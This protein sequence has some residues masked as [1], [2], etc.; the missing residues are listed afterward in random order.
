MAGKG[1][2]FV[3]REAR[4]R[5]MELL[6]GFQMQ[7]KLPAGW[8]YCCLNTDNTKV[9][10][11]DGSI[12]SAHVTGKPQRCG[13]CKRLPDGTYLMRGAEYPFFQCDGAKQVPWFIIGAFD[14]GSAGWP[15][16]PGGAVPATDF[17]EFNLVNGSTLAQYRIPRESLSTLYQTPTFTYNDDPGFLQNFS[18][19]WKCAISPD[20]KY[21]TIVRVIYH[22]YEEVLITTATARN[23]LTQTFPEVFYAVIE[24]F[25]LGANVID[26]SQATVTQG[27][28]LYPYSG[29]QV[30]RYTPGF[31]N[32][33]TTVETQQVG[34]VIGYATDGSPII[35]LVGYAD[36]LADQVT[37]VDLEY[38]SA[39]WTALDIAGANSIQQGNDLIITAVE[40]VVFANDGVLETIHEYKNNSVSKTA[41]TSF[42]MFGVRSGN[43]TATWCVERPHQFNHSPVFGNTDYTNPYYDPAF[44][45]IGASHYVVDTMRYYGD[46]N[47][48]TGWTTS[49][50]KLKVVSPEHFTELRPNSL[51]GGAIRWDIRPWSF[52][53][54]NATMVQG[55]DLQ[56]ASFP[57]TYAVLRHSGSNTNYF[58]MDWVIK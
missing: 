40:N 35:D 23:L 12:H 30:T 27:S 14:T 43:N 44:S 39:I 4:R 1:R 33:I 42:N 32:S 26:L 5:A 8:D 31:R 22:A 7:K 58:M 11:A 36:S 48:V 6:Q 2:E 56:S 37:G 45:N 13:P 28:H 25:T 54:N 41:A 52:D 19:M 10:L 3:E 57:S 50:N 53:A 20:L 49:K 18:G 55:T 16:T 34:I 38:V 9:I 29:P 21:I 24:N 15:V 47:S 51:S 17:P 46:Y